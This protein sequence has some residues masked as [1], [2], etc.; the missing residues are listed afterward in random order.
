VAKKGSQVGEGVGVWA[1]GLA[2]VLAIE[3]RKTDGRS[4]SQHRR[5][6]S[7][8]LVVGRKLNAEKAGGAVDW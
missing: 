7:G 4:V 6:E 3:E 8:G 2:T 5:P 1:A